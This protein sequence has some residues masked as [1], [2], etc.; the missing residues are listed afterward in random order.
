MCLLCVEIAKGNMNAREV[1]RAY[2]EQSEM[3]DEHI[4]EVMT[5]IVKHYGQ[6]GFREVGE[7]I[8]KEYEKRHKDETNRNKS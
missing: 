5:E 2:V 1:A 7:E 6:E 8:S 3:D 4:Y